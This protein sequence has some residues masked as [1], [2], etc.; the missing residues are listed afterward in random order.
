MRRFW[1]SLVFTKEGDMD[2]SWC[3]CLICVFV[4]CVVFVL[5]AV[6]GLRASVAAWSWL[7]TTFAATLI[8]AVPI[9]KSRLL[10]NSRMVGD[11]AHGVASA[12]EE[13]MSTDIYELSEAGRKQLPE[14]QETI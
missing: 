2:W 1:H 8:S 13:A 3:L 14:S 4:G 12:S 10:A 7:G 11:V 5:E 6:T 9:A